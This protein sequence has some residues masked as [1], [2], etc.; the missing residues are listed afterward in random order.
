MKGKEYG[1]GVLDGIPVALAYLAV[2]FTFGLSAANFGLSPLVATLI[3]ATNLTS[4]GQFAGINLI[5]VSASVVEIFFAV[6]IINAR[7]L[8]M[9]LSLTQ[10]LPEKT[11]VV[12]RLLMSFF[13]TDE[14]FAITN[15]KAEKL[16]FAYFM[17]VA[18]LPYFAWA[19]GTLCGSLITS[20]LPVTLQN[21]MNIALYCMFIAII[22]PPAKKSL[23]VAVCIGVAVGLSCLFYYTPYLKEI[24][25]G[26]RIIIVS[27]V[28]SAV[29]ALIF[30]VDKKNQNKKEAN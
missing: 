14:I 13:V 8:L 3:S 30:P 26:I 6:L 11:S 18:T 12:K 19:I 2:S 7:Y 17:G 4:A 28:T 27:V 29:L 15:A 21:A 23:P 22:L 1:K 25:M 24:S 5:A 9:S 16:T 10:Y 20:I